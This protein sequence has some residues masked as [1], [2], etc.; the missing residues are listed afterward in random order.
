MKCR[1][2]EQRLC[3]SNFKR[4][5]CNKPFAAQCWPVA[6]VVLSAHS[7]RVSYCVLPRGYYWLAFIVSAI[8]P[9]FHYRLCRAK[10]MPQLIFPFLSVA[11]FSR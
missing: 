10:T 7:K 11:D 3:I 8:S 2:G 9:V 4:L 1:G 5:K 6:S